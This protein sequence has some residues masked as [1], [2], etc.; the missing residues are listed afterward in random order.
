MS[1]FGHKADISRQCSNVRYW[2]QSGHCADVLQCLLADIGLLSRTTLRFGLS[3]VVDCKL[4]PG[5]AL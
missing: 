3:G 1:A 5:A 4:E 2:G